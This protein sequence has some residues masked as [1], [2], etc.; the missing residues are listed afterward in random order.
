M[1]KEQQGQLSVAEELAIT[2]I[3]V[4]DFEEAGHALLA[5][6]KENPSLAREVALKILHDSLGDV[7]YRA[8]AFEVL[9]SAAF[10][11]ALAYIE[12]NAAVESAY[13][14][15][16]MVEAITE[17]VGVL[18]NRD[19]VLRAASILKKALALRPREELDSLAIKKA[20]FYEAY[21]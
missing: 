4:E 3:A 15:G 8:L 21:P 20:R 19:K 14:L 18:V 9:Y 13:V 1:K 7:Y 12:S 2:S 6:E 17:D 16:A 5:L 11:D 10:D